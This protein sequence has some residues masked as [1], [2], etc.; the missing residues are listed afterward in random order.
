LLLETGKPGAAEVEFEKSARDAPNRYR[1]LLGAARAAA[2]SG[3]RPK[4][5]AFYGQLL[6]LAGNADSRPADISEAR[7]YLSQ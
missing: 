2:E 7:N 5:R 4:A 3:D 1:G 6:K